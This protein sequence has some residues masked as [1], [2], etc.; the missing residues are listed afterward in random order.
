MIMVRFAPDHV[1]G[2]SRLRLEKGTH[3]SHPSKNKLLKCGISR[4]WRVFGAD[5]PE[6]AAGNRLEVRMGW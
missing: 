3:F 2:Y 1:Y 5:L 4:F 6:G